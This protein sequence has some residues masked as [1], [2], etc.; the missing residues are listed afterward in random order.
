MAGAK[1]AEDGRDCF[2]VAR[3]R[4]QGVPFSDPWR[5]LGLCFNAEQ[6]FTPL[7]QAEFVLFVAGHVF[8]FSQCFFSLPLLTNRI[9]FKH[10]FVIV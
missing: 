5:L 6:H 4:L 7:H 1:P 10:S 2:C 8:D 3:C 9:S